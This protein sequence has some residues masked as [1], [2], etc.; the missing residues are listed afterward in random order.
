MFFASDN[1]APTHPDIMAA[2]VR[3][4]EGYPRSYGADPLMDRV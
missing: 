4:N 1:T 3:A 2:I